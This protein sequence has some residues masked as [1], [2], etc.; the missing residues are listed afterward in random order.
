MEGLENMFGQPL[1]RVTASPS[2]WR[3]PKSET[4]L[5]L[6][7]IRSGVSKSFCLQGRKSS[8][9]INFFGPDFL[10]T[11]LTLTP[12]RPWV[13]KLRPI[14][15]TAEK[16]AFWSGRPRFSA[17]TSMTR[18]VSTNFVQKKRFAFD[19]LAPI[20]QERKWRGIN[21]RGT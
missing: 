20:L 15:G 8:I 10:R 7:I 21:L 13:K 1:L 18:R 14:T 5:S 6:R 17:R 12:G 9:N 4:V 11:F 3:T 16:P 19:F 2:P